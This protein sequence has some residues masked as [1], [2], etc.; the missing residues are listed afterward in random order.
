[1]NAKTI[2]RALTTIRTEIAEQTDVL[3]EEEHTIIDIAVDGIEA[4]LSGVTRRRMRNLLP[5]LKDDQVLVLD[6]HPHSPR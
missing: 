6:D 5:D 1:M 4:V 2:Q 3:K